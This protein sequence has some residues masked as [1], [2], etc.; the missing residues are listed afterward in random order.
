MLIFRG[1]AI[2]ALML[3][4]AGILLSTPAAR[5]QAPAD[6][7]AIQASVKLSRDGNLEVAEKV[8]VP[9]GGKFQMSL[10]LR[11][12][13]GDKGGERRFKVTDISSTGPGSAKVSGEVFTVDAPAGTS[14]FEYTV[15]NTVSDAP[16]TQVFQWTGILQADVASFDATLISPSYR[17]GIIDCKVGPQT[18][19]HQCDATVEPDGKLV[20]HEV[21]L[22]RGDILDVTLQ[23]PPGT[24]PANADISDGSSNGPFSI[25]APV[26][27]AFGVLIVAL[28]AL[29]G[30]VLWSR[31]Q[32]AAALRGDEVVDPVQRKG[33]RAQFVSPDGVL[34]GEAGLLLD[35]S[36][37]A[38]DLAS[39]VV[40]LAVRRY[41]WVT[42]VS[43]SD[44]RI[45][46]LNPADEQLREFER[47]V[48]RAVLPEGAESILLS[49]LRGRAA[50][51]P[52]RAALRADALAHGVLIDR[53]RRGLAFWLGAILV[54][55][56]VAATVGLAISGGYALVGVAIALGGVAALL[57]PAY[58]P[59]RT[60]AGRALAGRVRGLQR[61]LETIQVEMVPPAEREAAFSRGLPYTIIGSR[62]DNWIRTFREIDL[63]ADREPGLYWF[64]GFEQDR[65]LSR[66]A[67]HFPYFITALEGVFP[68]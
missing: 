28:L 43:E 49:E 58:L 24:V 27:I 67:G 40:D 63:A 5:A 33:S 59:A 51:E 62:S 53:K 18:G 47:E 64:G 17:M 32:D 9:Q 26:L 6:G 31:R 7:V 36:V 4:L 30:Y 2:S 57:L 1:G 46:R 10:P 20:L 66:F 25:T 48:Y 19:T 29:G 15:H 52:A 16:G 34:P 68:K 65:D 21:N 38:V 8:T 42:P 14:S 50:A 12:A 37:D 60:A 56:G 39:T 61:G 45:T 44:W 23:L 41:I 11:V 13:L 35:N 54:V 22:H 3:A 55:V